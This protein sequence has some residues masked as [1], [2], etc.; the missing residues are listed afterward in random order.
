MLAVIAQILET[1]VRNTDHSQ[2]LSHFH[3]GLLLVIPAALLLLLLHELV[4]YLVI[5]ETNLSQPHPP[6]DHLLRQI[7]DQRPRHDLIQRRRQRLQPLLHQFRVVLLFPQSLQFF[8]F[9]PRI[10]DRTSSV[11]YVRELIR[12]RLF[13]GDP[14]ILR[15]LLFLRFGLFLRFIQT[16]CLLVILSGASCIGLFLFICWGSWASFIPIPVG[17]FL[18]LLLFGRLLL[19]D[20]LHLLPVLLL[21]LFLQFLDHLSSQ[22]LEMQWL[23]VQRA[24]GQP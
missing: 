9:L 1:R 3:L 16:L 20:P 11:E 5:P 12:L 2:C 7:H 17:A 6:P 14:F 22:Q 21:Q 10:V 24:V 13:V 4:L 8:S 23:Q 15:F 18:L 19:F